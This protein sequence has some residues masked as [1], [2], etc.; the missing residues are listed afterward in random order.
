MNGRRHEI[1]AAAKSPQ[2]FGDQRTDAGDALDIGAAR[3]NLDERLQ[4]VKQRLLALRESPDR[5]IRLRRGAEWRQCQ[6]QNQND[7]SPA[8]TAH[9][10]HVGSPSGN[11]PGTF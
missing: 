6:E 3:F 4:R 7:G 11:R 2:P 9:V 10:S 1:D 8:A 5:V